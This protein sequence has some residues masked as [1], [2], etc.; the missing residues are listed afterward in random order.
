MGINLVSMELKINLDISKKVSIFAEELILLA[1]INEG[2]N[3]REI[4]WFCDGDILY[5]L[6]QLEQNLW[7]KPTEDGYILR[8]KG[9]QLFESKKN[10]DTITN[11]ILYLNS[12]ADKK[13]S[14]KTESNRKFIAAR[15]D[16][17]YSEGELKAVIDTMCSKWLNDPKMNMYLRPETLFNSTKFQ[18]YYNLISNGGT[19]WTRNIK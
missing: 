3:P 1:L 10:S 15:L 18:T 12:I 2:I 7:I 11:I 14:T 16:E 5:L 13:F 19:D 8:E 9:K 17:G 4:S 6:N